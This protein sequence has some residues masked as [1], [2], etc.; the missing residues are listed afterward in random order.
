MIPTSD[1]DLFG[2]D[3]LAEPY[4]HY[5]TLRDLGPVVWLERHDVY[6]VPRYADVRATLADAGTFCSGQGVGLND[7][8]N[9]AG[10]GTTLM[11]DG[12]THDR[13]REVIGR[14][15]TPKA[16]AELRPDVQALAHDLVDR[17]VEQ[18]SFDAVGDLAEVIPV[19]WVPDLLGWPADGRDQ[20]LT[21]AA[22]NFDALG[23][24]NARTDAAGP[25][26]M[27]MV[28]YAQQVAF[29]HDLPAGS[30]AA[31][32]LAA[33]ARGDIEP[34]QCPALLV[35]YLAPSLDTTISAIGNAVWLFAMHPDQ[36]DRLRREP[37]RVKNAFNEVLRLESPI[38]CF[39][40]VATEPTEVGGIAV[41]EGARLLMMYASANRDERRW[42]R[43]DDFDIGREAAGQLGFG[44]GVHACAGM[45][46]ARLE[47]AAVLSALAAR[48][49]RIELGTPVRKLNN[50]IRAFGSLPVTVH[51]A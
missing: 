44:H 13:Q 33:A 30:M 11:S 26:L 39:T 15:L 3:A 51:P 6:A 29:R 9:H 12:A 8:I 10:R 18:G 17:L 16:L 31:G 41:P 14:P 2:D 5:R 43:A 20:L 45:G 24:P 50:L 21:W 34:A 49:E 32:V 37:E 47:G 23:P 35:D 28:G 22:A 36:W 46:L 27:A 1:V 48:V 38:S 40:R 7:F 25:G 4:D 19:T 42:E